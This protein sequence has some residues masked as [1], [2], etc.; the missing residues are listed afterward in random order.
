MHLGFVTSA[1]APPILF[2]LVRRHA[3]AIGRAGLQNC[4]HQQSCIGR[5]WIRFLESDLH[6]CSLASSSSSPRL[7]YLFVGHVLRVVAFNTNFV[8][9]IVIFIRSSSS[10]NRKSRMVPALKLCLTYLVCYLRIYDFA[11]YL[12]QYLLFIIMIDLS[13]ICDTTTILIYNALVMFIIYPWIKIK[14]K[15]LIF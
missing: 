8:K 5:G 15:V 1:A 14:L 4:C 13:R 7:I 11:R 10:R 6:D 9:P 3:S 2:H 12:L